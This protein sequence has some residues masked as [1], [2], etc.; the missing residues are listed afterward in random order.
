MKI[1]MSICLV[2]FAVIFIEAAQAQQ[3]IGDGSVLT[4]MG[5]SPAPV[6]QAVN[7]I[8]DKIPGSLPVWI[9]SVLGVLFE[10]VARK[11]PTVKPVSLLLL[12]AGVFRGISLIF[13]KLSNLLD[14]VIGQN[15]KAP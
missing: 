15:T 2:L 6:I 4:Q 9:V 1:L 3:I 13:S 10:I 8:A 11:I 5:P 7:D 12:V 14:Q